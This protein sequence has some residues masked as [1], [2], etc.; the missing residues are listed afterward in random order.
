MNLIRTE[1]IS[2]SATK[3]L[4]EMC[5]LSKNL[6]NEANYLIRQEFFTTGK[7]LRYNELY[8][9]IKNSEN[10]RLLPI[11]TSQQTLRLLDK[12]WK[13]AFA[14]IKTR[15]QNPTKFDG[16][17]KL[18][19]Y[20]PKN[21]EGILIFTPRQFKIKDGFL[22]LPQKIPLKI[23][24]RLSDNTIIKIVR[25]IPKGINYICEIVYKKQ[26]EEGEINK[27]WY[28][29]LNNSNRYIGIDLGVSN[30]VTMVNNIGK[31]PIVIKGGI[32]KSINQFYNKE[33]ARL[34][35]IYARQGIKFGTKMSKL[36]FNRNNRIKDQ[37]H[38]ISRY[39]IDYCVSNNIGTIV[40]GLNKGWK[41]NINIGKRNNQNFVTIPFHTLIQMIQ[42]KAEE[43]SIEVKLQEEAHIKMLFP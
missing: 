32:L 3:E 29:K 18:P 27:R 23:K 9:K 33:T 15:R 17:V 38:K 19:Y 7:W 20:K 31:Q 25:I 36:N 39:I 8:W 1:Q 22:T 28:S 24:T 16:Q 37:I 40:I 14:G 13:S 21:G 35:S 11:N 10:Y 43:Q 4:S 12:A 42:Y 5:H 41:Q 30:I 34:Q 26:F 2:I 6:W